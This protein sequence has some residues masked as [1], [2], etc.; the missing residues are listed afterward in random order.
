LALS[1]TQALP[2]LRKT[3]IEKSQEFGISVDPDTY[4]RDLSVGEQQRVEILRCL[5][6]NPKIIE[7]WMSRPLS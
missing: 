4:I 3:I 5:L 1:D 7:L 2:E 6:Q